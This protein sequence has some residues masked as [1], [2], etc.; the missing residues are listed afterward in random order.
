MTVIPTTCPS[1]GE[2]NRRFV[3]KCSS[4][5]FHRQYTHIYA[6]R[7]AACRPALVRG[8]QKKWGVSEDGI[9]KSDQPPILSLADL[10]V[11]QQ[12]VIIGTIYK[13][14]KLK[15]SIL[16]ELASSEMS[17]SKNDA[18]DES[19]LVSPDDSTFL[20][21]EVQRIMLSIDY[22][23]LKGRLSRS[24]LATGIVM[25]LLGYEPSSNRG[26]FIVKDF[27]FIEP[28]PERPIQA[29][30]PKAPVKNCVDFTKTGPWLALVSG[31]GF[32]GTGP[33]RP[34]H[35]LALELLADWL[36]CSGNWSSK[37]SDSVGVVRLLILGD[38]IRLSVSCD[39]NTPSLCLNQQARYLTRNV[40]AESVTAMS[41]LDH[42]LATLPLGPGGAENNGLSVDLLPGP[43]DPTSSLLPQQPVHPVA[44]PL[45]VARSGEYGRR[46]LC[47]RTNPYFFT[48]EGRK[49]L[50][51]AG[52]GP[53][54]LL[55]YTDIADSCERIEATLLWGHLAPTCPDTLPGY[56]MT[57]GD[58]LVLR[59]DTGDLG[60][61]PD[62][63]DIYV[64]GC[65]PGQGASWRRGRLH[66]DDK[67]HRGALLV[68]VPRFDEAFQLV[69]VHLHSLECRVV[70][71]DTV[72]LDESE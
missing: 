57:S 58:Q 33:S 22:E 69:L 53:N 2:E 51:T 35:S 21:D 8:S 1:D 3:V 72:L 40:E 16:R 62:Y 49:I 26:S 28:Q 31:L 20:E 45:S 24:K 59:S 70:L 25:A 36:R 46:A 64:A 71:F 37:S 66:W 56:P 41:L 32:S 42:W 6:D 18:T 67:D 34:G 30:H 47:G 17:Y 39:A 68:A 12:C 60:C 19:Y 10:T 14:M 65:Q 5:S 52:Q 61:S 50:A 15:P 11:D 4:F 13:D 63:P 7:L 48:L 29:H 54:D 44:F 23:V 43:A 9:E 38:S 55:L 27:L